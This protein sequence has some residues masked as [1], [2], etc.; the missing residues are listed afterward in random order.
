MWINTKKKILEEITD[1]SRSWNRDLRRTCW[2]TVRY[3][4]PFYACRK[5]TRI[6]NVV[7]WADTVGREHRSPHLLSLEHILQSGQMNY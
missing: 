5:L 1:M 6:R 7:P 3:L 4:G 2:R